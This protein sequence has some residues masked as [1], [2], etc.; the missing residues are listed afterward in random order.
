M[1]T[2]WVAAVVV[3]LLG[4]YFRRPLG[5]CIAVVRR[6]PE[7]IARLRGR[8]EAQSDEVVGLKSDDA[9]EDDGWGDDDSG[10][11][12]FSP[13]NSTPAAGVLRH[14]AR[15][16]S[17]LSGRRGGGSAPASAT[18]PTLSPALSP[19]HS[20]ALVATAGMS[21]TA[22]AAAAISWQV[23]DDVEQPPPSTISSVA[24][25]AADLGD[26]DGWGDDDGANGWGDDDA[27]GDEDDG[28]GESPPK[29]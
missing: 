7:T 2:Y 19:A 6:T 16:G 17:A 14:G 21:A 4:F 25:A 12:G 8:F 26:G 10:F 1:P 15:A 11:E 28:W 9:L 23:D 27:W 20:P 22:A 5:A 18:K 24:A 13:C 29:P 3:A